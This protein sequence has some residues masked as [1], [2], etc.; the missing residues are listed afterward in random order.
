VTDQ[1]C[2][3][4]AGLSHL[5]SLD[6]ANTNISDRGITQLAKLPN[7]ADLDVSKT[8]VTDAGIALLTP[9]DHLKYL[10]VVS[11]G[12]TT[13][14]VKAL[15]AALPKARIYDGSHAKGEIYATFMTVDGEE[16][17]LSSSWSSG[18]LGMEDNPE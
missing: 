13:P 2:Q 9:R 11:T 8:K 3:F 14:G 1:G 15:R 16:D 17:T 6:L 12:V 7:L 10:N 4:V 18:N 5:K